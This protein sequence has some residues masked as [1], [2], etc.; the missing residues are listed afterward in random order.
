MPAHCSLAPF[1]PVILFFPILADVLLTLAWRLSRGR[2]LLKSH[3]DHLYQVG[4]RS[5]LGHAKVSMIYWVV[6]LV[7]AVVG[8]AADALQ[9]QSPAMDGAAR[10]AAFG[11]PLIA[12]MLLAA[13]SV[14]ISLRVR[15]FAIAKGLDGD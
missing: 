8:Y 7:C 2:S 10:G 13:L 4:L 9:K 5:R 3:R 11:A 14:L 12:W 15:K 6:A 1:V